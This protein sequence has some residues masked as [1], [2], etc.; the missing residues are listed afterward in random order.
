MNKLI[1]ASATFFTTIASAISVPLSAQTPTPQPSAS[2]SATPSLPVGGNIIGK[3]QCGGRNG[4]G[5]ILLRANG[6][7]TAKDENGKYQVTDRGY[8]F[9]SSSLR[10]QS[11]VKYNK[12]LYM[13]DTKDETKSAQVLAT[14]TTAQTMTCAGSNRN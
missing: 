5:E 13:V 2:P 9:L 1:A 10:G 4:T 3:F 14:D 12:N 6:Y 11:I 8:R 7:Y